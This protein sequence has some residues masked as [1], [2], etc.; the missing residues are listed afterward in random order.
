MSGPEMRMPTERLETLG[1]RVRRA[2]WAV[3]EGLGA[4]TRVVRSR[5]AGLQDDVQ[6]LWAPV[7]DAP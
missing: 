2:A 6:T 5:N 3:S 7:G 4:T 1:P